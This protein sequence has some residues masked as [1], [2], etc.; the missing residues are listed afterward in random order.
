VA[1]CDARGNELPCSVRCRG[2]GGD[3]LTKWAIRFS[4]GCCWRF[5]S[6][7]VCCCCWVR[8]SRRINRS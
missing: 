3:F 6:C 1:G 5:W 2:E 8:S 4:H 7:G